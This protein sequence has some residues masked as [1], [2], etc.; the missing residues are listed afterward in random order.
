MNSTSPTPSIGPVNDWF[1]KFME[2]YQENEDFPIDLVFTAIFYGLSLLLIIY[3][4]S[5]IFYEVIA[6]SSSF[7]STCLT[8]LPGFWWRL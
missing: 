8:V 5:L 4:I 3:I 2:F 6:E 7:T 1:D